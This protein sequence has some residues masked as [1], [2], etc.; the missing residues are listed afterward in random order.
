[1]LVTARLKETAAAVEGMP[2]WHGTPGT[3]PPIWKLRV[4]AVV[5]EGGPAWPVKPLPRVSAIRQGV[6]AMK[7]RGGSAGL[8]ASVRA[9]LGARAA[10]GV[11]N[12]GAGQLGISSASG[13][14]SGSGALPETKRSGRTPRNRM[15]RTIRTSSARVG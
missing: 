13:I 6:T 14:T 8:T 12:A 5:R 10:G 15:A 11:Q 4:D 3:V 7:G 2:H 9:T 1:M